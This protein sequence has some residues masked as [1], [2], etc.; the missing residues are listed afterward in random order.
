MKR[1]Y[2]RVI[3]LCCFLLMFCNVGI[4]STSF[5]VYQPYIVAIPGVGDSG[6]SFV[7]GLRTC[8]S[9]VCMFVVGKYFEI[10]NCRK[11]CFLASLLTFVGMTLFGFAHSL[12][13]LFL[14][15]IF[16]GAAYGLGGMVGIT[17]LINRWFKS[18]VGFAVGL[19]TVGSGVASTIIPIIAE[20]VISG[21]S[22]AASF[23]LEAACALVIAFVVGAL[24]RNR[25]EDMGLTPHVKPEDVPTMEELDSL[26]EHGLTEDLD[27]SEEE[28]APS[29]AKATPVDKGVAL[30]KG[31]H[32]LFTLAMALIG[33]VVVAGGTFL[34]VLLVSE[35][36]DHKFAATMLSLF[37]LSLLVSKVITGKLY[38]AIGTAKGT[39]VS[40]ICTLVGLVLL[41]LAS[42]GITALVIAGSALSGFGMS[43]AT[44]G[45]PV[46][47]LELSSVADR[48]HTIRVF[49]LGYTAGSFIYNFVPGVLK[50]LVGNYVISYVI[51]AVMTLVAFLVVM[52]V[53]LRYH[54]KAA[55]PFSHAH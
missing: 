40:F 6:G 23:W 17:L 44:V 29:H 4:P 31:V 49:Q 53:Y 25:P 8:V 2:E 42:S 1:H 3:V 28:D 55:L 18:D 47:S 13:M 46:W 45:L 30:P 21:I 41:C 54:D 26:A 51:M 43:I 38:D 35:G 5:N 16:S 7:I 20:R 32:H 34:S 24:L 39:A 52:G 22:L 15:A 37:G 14:A 11:G 50:D 27:L 12:P 9:M 48:A 33:A 10:L 36:F 19:S